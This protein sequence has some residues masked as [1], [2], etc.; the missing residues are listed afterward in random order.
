MVEH[1]NLMYVCCIWSVLWVPE[2]CS[3][4][5][6]GIYS[7]VLF[8]VRLWSLQVDLL[9]AAAKT[10]FH[11]SREYASIWRI[12][13]ILLVQFGE[14]LWRSYTQ[15]LLIFGVYLHYRSMQESAYAINLTYFFEIID[16]LSKMD[17]CSSQAPQEAKKG[18]CR[19]ANPC[20]Y[21][22]MWY[23]VFG[24]RANTK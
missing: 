20:E 8:L 7:R 2:G 24:I 22:K 13:R 1:V 23:L 19:S 21:L 16:G 5:I 18:L 10:W 6:Y 9:F 17:S 12:V 15:R 14:V 11:Y 4:L 3:S